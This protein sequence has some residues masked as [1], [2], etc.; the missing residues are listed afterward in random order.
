MGDIESKNN[1]KIIKQETQ[2]PKS[3]LQKT[4]ENLSSVKEF[5]ECKTELANNLL[6]VLSKLG[7]TTSYHITALRNIKIEHLSETY[8]S[9]NT[10]VGNMLGAGIEQYKLVVKTEN[11]KEVTLFL[12][13]KKPEGL[14]EGGIE[15]STKKISTT[16]DKNGNE[17]SSTGA[18][19]RRALNT[20]SNDK[21]LHNLMLES[22][23]FRE[24]CSDLMGI[25]NC[26]KEKGEK[27]Q[28]KPEDLRKLDIALNEKII[29]GNSAYIISQQRIF[30]T[31]KSDVVKNSTNLQQTL[32]MANMCISK[33][34]FS[35]PDSF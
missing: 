26:G 5:C 27:T 24:L 31:F 30:D 25:V 14:D 6:Q 10:I 18:S 28:I 7:T 34:D 23:E 11:G 32:S 33:Y 19:L 12:R 17:I 21:F 4:Y 2:L 1:P 35:M 20:N 16:L 15:F 3:H 29:K 13:A 8:L 9:P 22:P